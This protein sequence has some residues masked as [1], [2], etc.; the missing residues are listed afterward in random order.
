M[1]GATASTDWRLRYA[2]YFSDFVD[3]SPL[4]ATPWFQQSVPIMRVLNPFAWAICAEISGARG[5]VDKAGFESAAILSAE[6]MVRRAS[7]SQK[8]IGKPAEYGR[9]MDLRTPKDPG[10]DPIQSRGTVTQ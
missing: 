10:G 7:G 3:N 2:A 6:Q 8:M 1:P 9:M 5:D 4:P